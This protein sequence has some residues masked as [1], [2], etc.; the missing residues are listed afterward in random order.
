MRSGLEAFCARIG[1]DRLLVQ[2]AG[3]NVSWKDDAGGL[4]VKA[5]GTWLADAL[6]TPLFVQTSL[7]SVRAAIRAGSDVI[8]GSDPA[9]LRPSIE[10]MLHALL[11]QRVVVHLHAVDVLASLVRREGAGEQER[12]LH[13]FGWPYGFVRY[14]R[15]GPELAA[16]VAQT[17][18]ARPEA[19]LLL[20]ESHGIALGG[21]T[22]QEIDAML[23]ELCRRFA[24]AGLHRPD[25][26]DR[27]NAPIA[28]GNGIALEPVVDGAGDFH[29]L[30]CDERWLRRLQEDWALYP[31]HLVFLGR[32]PSIHA[33]VGDAVAACRD[34]RILPGL[35]QFIAGAGTF[36]ISRLSPARLAQLRCYQD[37]LARQSADTL[38]ASLPEHEVD[39]L[40]DW[41]AERYRQ[42]LAVAS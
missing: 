2:G 33:S 34:G 38:L 40:L 32:R 12:L 39:Q 6:R 14:A 7:A 36:S 29:S 10:T 5:S 17:L 37:V 24:P 28:V 41:E 30:A 27:A 4:W 13:G 22:L 15:P 35:P 25:C 31:D 42:S 3:G 8:E 20:L 11:P 16:Q 1:A 21:A 18:E 19:Q 9:G 23:A 26:P